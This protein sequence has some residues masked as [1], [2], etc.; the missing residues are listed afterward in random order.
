MI[1]NHHKFNVLDE[2]LC[3]AMKEKIRMGRTAGCGHLD[4]TFMP[5][6]TIFPSYK[7]HGVPSC[8]TGPKCSIKCILV[9][10]CLY[11]PQK[12]NSTVILM[13]NVLRKPFLKSFS[14]SD[15]ILK[16][17]DICGTPG[18]HQRIWEQWGL[19]GPISTI[20]PGLQCGQGWGGIFW[21][22]NLPQLNS[23]GSGVD[24]VMG[25]FSLWEWKNFS[26]FSACWQCFLHAR[27][28]VF[29]GVR[30]KLEIALPFLP[31]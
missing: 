15:E 27:C 3:T 1:Q 22:G 2:N 31:H 24:G 29:W 28:I 17:I 13:C 12:F 7:S 8:I 19:S 14:L 5:Q 4:N 11:W 9:K 10:L 18:W 6:C 20:R 30:S 26:N 25:L 16:K 21:S 23:A